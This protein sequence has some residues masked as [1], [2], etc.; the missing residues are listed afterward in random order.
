MDGM[1]SNDRWML[2]IVIVLVDLVLFALPLT[3][4]FAAYVLVARPTWLRTWVTELY[5]SP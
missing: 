1:T 2:A 3:G 4:L 5:D